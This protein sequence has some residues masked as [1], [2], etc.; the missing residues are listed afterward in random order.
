[1][2]DCTQT[3]KPSLNVLEDPCN[4]EHLST[5]CIFSKDAITYLGIAENESLKNILLAIVSK[6][7]EIE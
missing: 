1:M 2:G 6:L 7:Q 3:N 5:E 4:G